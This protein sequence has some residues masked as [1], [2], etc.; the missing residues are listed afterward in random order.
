MY[1]CFIQAAAVRKVTLWFYA[2]CYAAVAH[3]S[4]TSFR[5]K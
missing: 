1:F 5:W 2:L 4:A 3:T